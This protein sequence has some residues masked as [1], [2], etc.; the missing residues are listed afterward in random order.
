MCSVANPFFVVGD[1][2]KRVLFYDVEFHECTII[3]IN[4]MD[5]IDSKARAEV[6]VAFKY[7]YMTYYGNRVSAEGFEYYY[8]HN[9]PNLEFYRD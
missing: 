9:I 8:A 4:E 7:G 2:Y 1:T 5:E 6:V 3:N